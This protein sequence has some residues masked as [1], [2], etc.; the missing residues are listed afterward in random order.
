M[1]GK[2]LIVDDEYVQSMGQYFRNQGDFLEEC[3]S[4][5]LRLLEVA[6]SAGIKEGASADA[7]ESFTGLARRLEGEIKKL[8]DIAG[9]Y[10]DNFLS[11]VDE[12]DK[13]LY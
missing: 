11:R 2:E 4:S 3:L 12:E 5:Y 1:A 13:Y 10:A 9:S 8:S 7:L 6:K